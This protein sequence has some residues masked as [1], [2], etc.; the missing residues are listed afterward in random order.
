M[1][2]AFKKFP[3]SL[4]SEVEGRL[5]PN[6]QVRSRGSGRQIPPFFSISHKSAAQMASCCGTPTCYVMLQGIC[7]HPALL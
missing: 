5:K 7:L 3:E 4:A 1:Q 2:S 6:M